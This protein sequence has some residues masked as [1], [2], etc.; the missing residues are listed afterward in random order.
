MSIKCG[1]CKGRHETVAGVKDCYAGREES[2]SAIAASHDRMKDE[3]YDRPDP[4]RPPSQRSPIPDVPAGRYAVEFE[5]RLMFYR[6][7]RPTE[8]RWAGYTFLKVYAS[9]ETHAIREPMKRAR[10]LNRILEDGPQAAMLR[11]GREIGS[12][13][14]CGRTLTDEDSRARGIGPICA[15]RMGIDIG[16][17]HRGKRGTQ[18]VLEEDRTGSDCTPGQQC[19]DIYNKCSKHQMEYQRRFGRASNE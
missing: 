15:G 11:Y 14:H 2:K 12:C 5:G 19:T 10:I 16:R 8:G 17:R 6:V 3:G 9:D 1:N 7:D 13:G 4:I 18:P